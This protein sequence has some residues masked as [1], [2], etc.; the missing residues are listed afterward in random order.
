MKIVGAL[1]K[2]EEAQ[3]IL[4]LCAIDPDLITI[5]HEVQP[6][7]PHHFSSGVL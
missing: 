1:T 6:I 2:Q 5:V 4:E 7:L 3:G